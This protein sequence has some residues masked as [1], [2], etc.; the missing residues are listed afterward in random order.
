M[1]EAKRWQV[2]PFVREETLVQVLVIDK[3]DDETVGCWKSGYT[4]VWSASLGD[5]D[6]V[7]RLVRQEVGAHV[8]RASASKPTSYSEADLDGWA[9][10][11]DNLHAAT[12]DEPSDSTIAYEAMANRW[13][14][15]GYGDQ[16]APT[17][18]VRMLIAATEAG[19]M[20]ALSD[21]RGGNLDDEIQEWRPDLAEEHR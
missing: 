1:R 17:E 20:A 19:Y 11:I 7:R 5:K 3:A 12:A 9:E 10:A 2:V 6:E 14:E 13:S 4:D 15:F 21:I 8:M 18:V 16:H